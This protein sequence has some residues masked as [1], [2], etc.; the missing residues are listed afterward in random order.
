[1]LQQRPDH[2]GGKE[3]GG[4]I[5]IKRPIFYE[6]VS[7]VP[8]MKSKS[9]ISRY[10]ILLLRRPTSKG[11]AYYYRAARAH[12][13]G[14]QTSPSTHKSSTVRLVPCLLLRTKPHLTSSLR[15]RPSGFAFPSN[16][17]LTVK[18]YVNPKETLQPKPSTLNPELHT[19]NPEL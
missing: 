2:T 8:R 17:A 4:R 18:F 5:T 10:D 11:R 16:L 14:T 9:P 12:T 3:E 7:S 19:L 6:T 13:R 1:M 15:A